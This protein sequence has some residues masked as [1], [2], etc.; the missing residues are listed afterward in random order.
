[1]EFK[2]CRLC[3][4]E[5]EIN[6]FRKSGK[7][8]RKE[9]KTCENKATI[10]RNKKNKKHIL[11]KQKKWR[12]NNPE[13]L[14]KYREKNYDKI[15]RKEYNKKYYEENKE[16][17]KKHHK[18]YFNK[19]KDKIKE[20]YKKWKNNNIEKVREY[21]RKDA[22]KRK[23]DPLK[24]LELQLRNMINTSF[25][26]KG[27]VKSKKLELICGLNSKELVNYLLNTFKENYGYEWNNTEKVHIDHIIPL[28]TAKTIEDVYR[29]CYYS[30]LQL[31]KPKD[32]FE[33]G[34]KENWVLQ[35]Q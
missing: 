6:Q 2:K 28:K 24:K 13:K 3:N 33:K 34:A 17:Y 1:M 30:N 12:D 8:I 22:L 11:E 27:Q 29:L 31:L 10:E 23:Q 25:K 18:D 16:Y 15:K 19:N 14:Q 20:N 9:C 7:Y 32:N 35:S 5:K 4:E 21:Q 26:R